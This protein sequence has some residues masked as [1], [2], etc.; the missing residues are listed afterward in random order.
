MYAVG[1]SRAESGGEAGQRGPERG[2]SRAGSR[3][4]TRVHEGLRLGTPPAHTMRFD[5]AGASWQGD[6]RSREVKA[7]EDSAEMLAPQQR[8]KTP[9]ELDVN[10]RMALVEKLRHLDVQDADGVQ[11]LSDLFD[12]TIAS[13]GIGAILAR[14][15]SALEV[16]NALAQRQ[17]ARFAAAQALALRVL[18]N[19]SSLKVGAAAVANMGGLQTM[20]A[21]VKPLT[22]S[23]KDRE[24]ERGTIA[25]R[26]IC[27]V[28]VNAPGAATAG[29]FAELAKTVTIALAL[30]RAS[31]VLCEAACGVLANVAL[32]AEGARAMI[33]ANTHRML[34]GALRPLGCTV[35]NYIEEF[36]NSEDPVALTP[37]QIQS[38]WALRNLSVSR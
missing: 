20:L 36:I 8:P 35:N 25:L 29:A 14:D 2:P 30:S 31:D 4:G 3:E 21:C 10:R 24:R 22:M 7:T 16:L 34:F 26:C 6:T 32:T 33:H 15:S 17:S 23:S 18:L 38:I 1:E 11:C 19:V 27:N 28:L 5:S 37:L 12:A 9:L 13:D